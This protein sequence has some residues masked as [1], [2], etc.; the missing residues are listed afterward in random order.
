MDRG[1]IFTHIVGGIRF[2]EPMTVSTLSRR[3]R[4]PPYGMAA[5]ADG[6]VVERGGSDSGCVD[7]GPGDVHVIETPA[8]ATVHRPRPH[9][10]GEATDDLRAF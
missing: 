10:A 1:G 9:R 8:A 2:L 7:V 5:R 6:T 4:V 3:R